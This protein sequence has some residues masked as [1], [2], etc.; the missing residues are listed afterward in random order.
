[1]TALQ[2]TN[3]LKKDNITASGIVDRLAMKHP[4]H[5]HIY[6][7]ALGTSLLI[8]ITETLFNSA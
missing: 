6:P 1:M 7:T 3:N 5:C 4:V 8:G 2:S